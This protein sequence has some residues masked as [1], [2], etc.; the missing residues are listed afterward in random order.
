VTRAPWHVAVLVVLATAVGCR[1]DDGRAAA[2]RADLGAL[3]AKLQAGCDSCSARAH[4]TPADVVAASAEPPDPLLAHPHDRWDRP[5]RISV[6]A[7]AVKLESAGA[8][9]TFDTADD[10]VERCRLK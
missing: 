3:C 10:L 1:Q 9:G 8:D 7:G 5:L 4:G 2:T 6:N